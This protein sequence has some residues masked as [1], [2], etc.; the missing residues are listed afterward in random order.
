MEDWPP[1]RCDEE[2]ILQKA[3][4]REAWQDVDRPTQADVAT[5]LLDAD[6]TGSEMTKRIRRVLL[7]SKELSA[8]YR[9]VERDERE[10]GVPIPLTP[11]QNLLSW[12]CPE[13]KCA[14]KPT[15]GDRYGPYGPITCKLHKRPLVLAP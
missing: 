8:L 1:P 15:P 2:R 4:G 5:T 11:P 10:L 9:A 3:M 12:K 6:L 13:A 7:Q 14:E